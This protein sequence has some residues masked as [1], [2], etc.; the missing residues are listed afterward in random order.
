[1]VRSGQRNFCKK[2]NVKFLFDS[3]GLEDKLTT[4]CVD[5]NVIVEVVYVS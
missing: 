4:C 5:W 2:I 3:S 1:M